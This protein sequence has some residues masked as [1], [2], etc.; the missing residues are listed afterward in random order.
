MGPREPGNE[1]YDWVAYH[2]NRAALLPPSERPGAGDEAAD[3]DS[4]GYLDDDGQPDSHQERLDFA[5]DDDPFAWGL[6]D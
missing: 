1:L 4:D 5:Q 3:D 6:D 2:E